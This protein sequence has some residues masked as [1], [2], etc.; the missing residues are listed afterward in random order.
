[1]KKV[2]FVPGFTGGKRDMYVIKRKLRNFELIYFSY[3]TWLNKGIEDYSK[4]LK[5]FID[6]LKLK[7]EKASIIGVSAGGIIA[8]YYLKFLDNKRVDKVITIC[9]PF[10]GSWVA[11]LF[12]KKKGMRQLTRDS[13]L[14]KK[15]RKTKLKGIKEK[16][17]WSKL[18]FIVPGDSGKGD[19]PEHTLFF[20]HPIIHWWPPMVNK[21]REFLD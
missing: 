7:K 17:I 8:E 13:H 3:D 15:L 11:Y 10:E 6:S 12:R 5:K 14:L 4:E 21:I 19:H 1:M 18:D 16:N 9:S 20:I 2:I